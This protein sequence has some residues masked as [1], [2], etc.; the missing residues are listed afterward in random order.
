MAPKKTPSE[1]D[2]APA[3]EKWPTSQAGETSSS[4][5]ATLS[6]L[7]VQSNSSRSQSLLPAAAGYLIQ[8]ESVAEANWEVTTHA[9]CE[10][11]EDLRASGC[12]PLLEGPLS[13]SD[14]CSIYIL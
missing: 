11:M 12:S 10:E 7:H 8:V 4:S 3:N 2:L 1:Q 9:L 13:Q 5:L 6:S 14:L